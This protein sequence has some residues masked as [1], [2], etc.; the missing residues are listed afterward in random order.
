M[1]T[2]YA[3]HVRR[4][5]VVTAVLAVLLGLA[6]LA[7]L[8]I[9]AF[10]VRP[11]D[12][13]ALL[14]GQAGAAVRH[15]LLDIR[16]PRVLA[17]LL[18]GAGLGLAGAVMQNVLRNPLASP[19]TLGVSQGA[20]FGAAFAIIVLGAGRVA[21]AGPGPVAV[22]HT[23]LVAGSAF[24][25]S[26]VTV[27]ALLILAAWRGL[28]PAALILAGVALSAF[29]SA[30]TMLLQYFAS[31][32]DVAAA[33]FWTFGDLGKAAWRETAV[34][35]VPL[36]PA[37]AYALLRRWHFNALLW[38]DD[39][40]RSLGVAVTRLRLAALIL[41]ALV[42]AATTACLGIIGFVGLIAPHIMRMLTGQDHRFL[43]PGSMLAG[44][45]LLLASDALARTVLAPI[46][47]PVGILTSFAG[48]P[49]FLF[50]LVRRG[51]IAP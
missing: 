39:T 15:V 45:L 9:G 47:L 43:L 4:R 36:V 30:A 34:I 49:L 6:A 37:A 26:L 24:V 17:A 13:S 29:F 18:A 46:V 19:F 42:A 50:L 41:A 31:D 21:A 11:H 48:V 7:S 10:P 27:A 35:A 23:Y 40:A 16:L 5:A 44:A 12:V 1:Q 22:H 14:T 28:G 33:V 32:I 38:G 51:G 2:R 25:G 20:A 8:C 3:R